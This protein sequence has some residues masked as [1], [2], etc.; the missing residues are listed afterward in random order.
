MI[1]KKEKHKIIIKISMNDD[2]RVNR[3]KQYLLRSLLP[4]LK[5]SADARLIQIH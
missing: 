2:F 1:K 3:G 5:S 4:S